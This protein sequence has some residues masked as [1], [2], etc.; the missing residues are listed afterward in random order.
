M[1]ATLSESETRHIPAAPLSLKIIPKSLSGT[2]LSSAIT[3]STIL[4]SIK[5]TSVKPRCFLGLSRREGREVQLYMW[6][7]LFA[8]ASTQA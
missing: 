4:S 1:P 3:S 6:V 5:P 7:T 2:C 8:P